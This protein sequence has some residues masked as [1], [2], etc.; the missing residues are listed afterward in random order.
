MTPDSRRSYVLVGAGSRG[1]GMYAL[2]ITQTFIQTARLL[3]IFDTNPLRARFVA[4][5]CGNVPVFDDF[6]IMLAQIQPDCVI[7]TSVDRFHHEYIIRALDTGCDV[8]SEKPLTID[9][10][11]C[12]AVLA[13]ERRSG[14]QLTVTFNYRFTPFTT[15][16]K[17]LVRGGA[18]GKVL[19][20]DFE[21][22]LDRSHGADYFRRWHAHLANSGGLL[23]HKATHHFDIVN[24][25]IDD[26]P[27]TVYARGELKFYGPTRAERG[28]TCRSCA[29]QST[30]EFYRDAAADPLIRA[31][32]LDAESA[33]GYLRDRCVFRPEI[34]IY[35]TMALT[36]AYRGGAF[37]TYSLVAYSP[38]EG[39]RLAINGTDGRLEAEDIESG[40][41]AAAPTLQC[42][43][44]NPRGEIATY[45]VPKAMGEHGGA[46]EQLLARLFGGVT[47]PDPLGHMAGSRA[48]AMSMLIGAAA[49]ESIRSGQVVRIDDLLAG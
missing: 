48:G 31:L 22:L 39:W 32:Y 19:S 9:A 46:D 2:P 16:I 14:K 40:F 41:R 13:A 10:E 15:R 34:D 4:S 6:E 27:E 17:E 42:R 11:K 29:H 25:W 35:D 5:R 33:D 1:L 47:L 43:V 23:V 8:I 21:W 18:V 37:L 7:V 30:C 26:E 28:E 24:W 38:Y 20:V 36:A 44:F 45:D 12:R 3:G 49:N